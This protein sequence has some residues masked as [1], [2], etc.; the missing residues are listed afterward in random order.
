MS[1]AT[2]FLIGGMT[3]ISHGS[4]WQNMFIC[5]PTWSPNNGVWIPTVTHP[6]AQY[7][8]DYLACS[9]YPAGSPETIIYVIQYDFNGNLVTWMK[10]DESQPSNIRVYYQV[11]SALPTPWSNASPCPG[12]SAASA[13][14]S[15]SGSAPVQAQAYRTNPIGCGM[16]T[17][18][19]GAG[20]MS[21][22]YTCQD[23]WGPRATGYAPTTVRP[24]QYNSVHD[25]LACSYYNFADPKDTNIYVTMFSAAGAISSAFT[26]YGGVATSH[27]S[28]NPFPVAPWS[29]AKKCASVPS[30]TS[31][32]STV[33][34]TTSVAS[35][36]SITST[37]SS[38]ASSTPAQAIPTP[39]STSTNG[40]YSGYQPPQ[41]YSGPSPYQ[42]PSPYQPPSKASK[43]RKRRS[44]YT[45]REAHHVY[46]RY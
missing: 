13:Q 40:D 33:V 39:L 34:S 27:T 35:T 15:C 21:R 42:T 41:D 19:A 10:Q 45:D 25:L 43:R 23:T 36:T 16:T 28:S 9:Y 22:N 30:T 29:V 38:V 24:M 14:A 12:S 20:C 32:T 6:S 3:P 5:P 26:L 44:Q 18:E 4:C 2:S 8:V 37:T 17:I 46:D 11:A 7:T 31:M 1:S